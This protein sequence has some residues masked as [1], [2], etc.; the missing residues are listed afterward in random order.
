VRNQT[1][2]SVG[3]LLLGIV[4]TSGCAARIDRPTGALSVS[5]L[6]ESPV[7]DAE[8]TIYG[9]V[10]ALGE[11]F[12]P[13]FALT[14]GGE[15]VDV[16]YDLMS[17]GPGT[18]WPAVNVEGIDNGDQVVVVG[19]LRPSDGLLASRTFWASRIEKLE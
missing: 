3:M 6:L 9:Q 2:V 8:V 17:E 1:A 13:C 18:E 16:W 14:S 15:S 4:L 12:C 5:E 11:L 10:S 19:Q 7:Y